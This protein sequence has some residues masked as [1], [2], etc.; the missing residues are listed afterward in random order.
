MCQRSNFNRVLQGFGKNAIV[1]NFYHLTDL[2][3]WMPTAST[4]SKLFVNE[5][6][7]ALDILPEVE[8]YLRDVMFNTVP[9]VYT[10]HMKKGL[11]CEK[12]GIAYFS[13][14]KKQ[15]FSKNTKRL[16]N[17]FIAGT[18]DLFLKKMVYD[19]KISWS[20]SSFTNDYIPFAY[21]CQ[22]Q[23]YMWLLGYMKGTI[24]KIFLPTPEAVNEE[25]ELETVE[26][27]IPWKYKEFS[28][29]YSPE[30]IIRM[31]SKIRSA[32]EFMDKNSLKTRL[33]LANLNGHSAPKQ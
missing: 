6:D 11:V 22:I 20:N 17:K 2:K 32:R 24:V 9:R 29:E 18:P 23:A 26:Q 25:F 30:L 4:V 3:Y 27:D 1:G 16:F 13:S 19:I 5:R 28:F 12:T 10:C 8:P 33:D 14:Q 21:K 7:T 15:V 31:M